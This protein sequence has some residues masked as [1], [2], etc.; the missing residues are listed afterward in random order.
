VPD[1]TVVEKSREVRIML[2]ANRERLAGNLARLESTLLTQQ[3]R[4]V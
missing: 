4:T 2:A 1:R 3:G